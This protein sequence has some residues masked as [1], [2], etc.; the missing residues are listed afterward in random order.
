VGEPRGASE[1]L[2]LDVA[3]GREQVDRFEPG[4]EARLDKVFSLDDEQS[5][6]LALPPAVQPAEELDPWIRR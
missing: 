5:E 1:H 4:G 6:P 3:P 2:R